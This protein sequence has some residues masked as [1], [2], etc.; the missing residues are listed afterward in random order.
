MQEEEI[1][2]ESRRSFLIFRNILV[3]LLVFPCLLCYLYYATVFN[4]YFRKQATMKYSVILPTYNEAE[5]IA[6]MIREL[7]VL[8]PDRMEIIVV[9]DH[10]PDGTAAAAERAAAAAGAPVRVLRNRGERGLSPSVAYGFGEA[11]GEILV[12]MDADGQHRPA[13]LMPLLEHME[14]EGAVMMTGSRHVAGGG[15]TERWS[16]FRTLCSRSA[17]IAARI[18]LGVTLKDPMS[19]FFAVQKRAFELVRPAMSP[20]GFKI[21]LELAW[22]FML[23]GPVP[24]MEHP[25]TFAMRE[26]GTSKLSGRVIGQY[27]SMLMR[28]IRTRTEVRQKLQET[29]SEK[30]S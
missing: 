3:F 13:D 7:A 17:A 16:L 2:N 11:S 23:A 18:C 15:F 25:I 9:D 4:S 6:A 27:L 20:S 10:S 28:C 21:M 12:C 24:V 5:N 1:A 22:L 19:G 14:R 26:H 29:L 8:A 30:L